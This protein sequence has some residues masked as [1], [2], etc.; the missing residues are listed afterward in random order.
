MSETTEG[1]SRAA[2]IL[3]LVHLL[4]AGLYLAF[5]ISGPWAKHEDFEA[6]ALASDGGTGYGWVALVLSISLVLLALLRLAGRNRLLPGIGVEQLTVMLGLAAWANSVAFF[7]GWLVTFPAGTGWAAVVAY[8][9]ASI[10]PQLGM[11]TLSGAD[12]DPNV[13]PIAAGPRRAFSAMALVA[14]VGVG[15]FPFLAWLTDGGAISLSAFDGAAGNPRSGPRFG[16]IL[17]IVAIIVV[18]G[19]FM[20]LRPQGLAEMGNNALAGHALIAG[21][22]VAITLPIAT[23]ISIAQFDG[24][25]LSA[26]I[27][28]WLGLLTGALMIV[29]GWVENRQRGAVG[30]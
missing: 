22:A 14:G 4:L 24:G 26:G 9:P 7:V 8:F 20:R 2:L 16:Y 11:L 1:T 5:T 15:L 18:V 25:G 12:P 3:G 29:I 27:G 19:A 6:G 21:G 10:I 13:K 23:Y 28:L 17:L 30:V